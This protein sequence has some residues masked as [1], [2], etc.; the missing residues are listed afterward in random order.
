MGRSLEPQRLRFLGAVGLAALTADI[1]GDGRVSAW[2]KDALARPAPAPAVWHTITAAG[3]APA[4]ALGAGVATIGAALRHRSVLRPG[5][6]V[7]GGVLIR[8]ALCRTIA[9]PRPP[10]E[11]WQAEP[12]GPSYPSRHT[13]WATLAAGAVVD[14]LPGGARPLGV[15]AAAVVVTAVG[16][17]RVRLGMHWPSD[18]VAGMLTA[19]TWRAVARLVPSGG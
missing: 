12:T 2:E 19:V 14:E 15:G 16:L 13:T 10:Q 5:L 9:R 6:T 17:S 4:L 8:T 18:V 7:L 11:W 3:E 1:V